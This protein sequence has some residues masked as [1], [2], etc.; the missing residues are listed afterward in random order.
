MCFL[1]LYRFILFCKYEIIAIEN[2][3][4]KSLSIAALAF[5]ISVLMIMCICFNAVL[6]AIDVFY[7]LI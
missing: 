2:D 5:V 7:N 1:L 3:K 4:V 6:M